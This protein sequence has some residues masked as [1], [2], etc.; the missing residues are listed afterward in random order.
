MV[1]G[2]FAV[3]AVAASPASAATTV[4]SPSLSSS[5]STP[6]TCSTFP[7]VLVQ[8]QIAGADVATPKGVITSWSVRNAGGTI[9]LRV[10]RGRRDE[11]VE[12]ELH[13]TN[14]SESADETGSGSDSAPQSFG[15]R[16]P[17]EAGDYIGITLVSG[18]SVGDL[19][20]SG[21][22]L[23]EVDGDLALTDVDSTSPENF[24]A[25][26]SARVEPDADGDG[27]GDESQDACP[28]RA[29]VQAAC[30][31]ASPPPPF[32]PPAPAFVP[33]PPAFVPPAST[34][35][36]AKVRLGSRSATFKRGKAAIKLKNANA[37]G[38]K[39]KLSLKLGKK[40]VGSR[41]YSLAA[42][43]AQA[44]KVKLAK[45]ARKRIGR[46]GKV[47]LSLIVTAKGATGKTFKTAAQL[48]V[49][50]ATRRKVNRR[51]EPQPTPQ[52]TPDS[53]SSLDGKYEK[54][55]NSGPN[56]IFSV[57]GG[58]RRIVDLRGS[59]A[60]TCYRYVPFSGVEHDFR[61]LFPA[62]AS[63]DVAADGS[64]SGSQELE[65]TTTEVTDGKLAGGIATGTISVRS[66]GCQSGKQNFKSR[67]TGP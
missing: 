27:F 11:S 57:T 18:S 34:A 26:F 8:D 3:S 23:F 56:I 17:V 51:A 62:I 40:V 42:G 10:L 24:E 2:G 59:I 49:K 28:S 7:C 14:V 38:V 21:D 35:A 31:V 39:G 50:K 20:S 64:F 37:V 66:S 53:G 29:D 25:L 12:G 44:V 43:V 47:K 5:G 6:V 15:S 32:V 16:Q 65:G 4:G 9:A 52:P 30:P 1:I 48:T 22:Q 46:R 58:G 61:A 19:A 54:D 45:A 60:G 36:T 41:S 33:P 67:R 63:I 13:A 55:P